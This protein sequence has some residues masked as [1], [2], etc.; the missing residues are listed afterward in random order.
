MKNLVDSMIHKA[1]VTFNQANAKMKE[2]IYNFTGTTSASVKEIADFIKN[3]PEVKVAKKDF[4]GLQFSF[5]EMELDGIYYYAEMRNS[6]TLQ[7]DV[8]A[9]N[10]QI[11]SYRSYR[12]KY[13]LQT[14]IKFPILDK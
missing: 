3:H 12:D 14:P 1:K 11:V 8:Q 4:L 5:Y 10:E 9:A 6:Y 13:S 7:V 2:R